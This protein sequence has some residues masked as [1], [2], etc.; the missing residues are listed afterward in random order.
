M[1]ERHVVISADTHCGAALH[2]YKPYLEKK[3]H[4]DFDE[5]AESVQAAERRIAEVF[6]D[7]ER[8]PLNVGVDGDPEVDGDRNW[9][10]ERRL[11]E[12]EADGVVAA[13]LFPNTQPPFA[14]AAASQFEAPPYSDDMVRRWAGL[15]ARP[16]PDHVIAVGR[17]L[18]LAGGRRCERWLGVGEQDRGHHAVGL[19]FSE[20]TLAGPVAVAVHLGVPV[21]THVQRRPLGVLEHLGD[22]PLGRLYRFGPLVEVL[23]V[24]LLQV[25]LVV[26]QRRTTVGVGRDDDVSFAHRVVTPRWSVGVRSRCRAQAYCI[27][28]PYSP[29]HQRAFSTASAGVRRSGDWPSVSG[30]G[31]ILS[32]TT[33]NPASSRP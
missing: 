4:E 31:P 29:I 28:Q 10:S 30:V 6:K 19:L 20:A 22:P 21:H 18:E 17:G 25:R 12:Q 24:L 26:V 8:S 7:A 11:R 27:S 16:S 5:W 3:Y 2:D 14:P 13:V 23:V 9:S 1:S 15:Q 32:A 33:R